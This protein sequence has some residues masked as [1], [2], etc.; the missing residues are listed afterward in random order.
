MKDICIVGYS[1]GHKYTS[2]IPI[3]IYSILKSYPDYSVLVFCDNKLD[4]QVRDN[5]KLLEGLGDFE[6]VENYKFGL[7]ENQ[8]IMGFP[9]TRKSLRWLFFDERFSDFKSIYIGDIDMFMCRESIDIYQQHNS[10]CEKLGLP[11]S[12]YIRVTSKVLKPS[13]K[14]ILKNL[15][16][17]DIKALLS[18]SKRKEIH[19]SRLTGL[20]FVK[21]QDYYS[22]ISP[23]FEE[24]IELITE[25][26]SSVDKDIYYLSEYDE[27]VLYKLIEKSGI[28]LP[29]ISPN[30]PGLEYN[31]YNSIS[32]RPHHGLHMGIFRSNFEIKKQ[33]QVLRSY[34]Y[35]EYISQY[36]HLID[37]DKLLTDIINNSSGFVKEHFLRME[38][39]YDICGINKIK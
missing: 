18:M 13:I 37:N 26:A 6:V 24:F 30:S 23:L 20:H 39:Y 4:D 31:D 27:A 3:Y 10:H 33:S 2:F 19:F 7:N 5:L 25:K 16:H 32:F 29:P 35:Q 15:F 36:K 28:G 22:K 8:K 14:L 1:Y 17:S 34:V 9:G 21:T 12:N 11:Y 38:Q